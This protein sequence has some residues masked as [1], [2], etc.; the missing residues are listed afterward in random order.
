MDISMIMPVVGIGITVV[1]FVSVMFFVFRLFRGL[2]KAQARNQELLQ[3][4]IP[5]PARVASVQM[6]GMTVTTGV[7]RNLQ[8]VI[9]LQV[10]PQGGQPYQAQMTTMVSELQVPQ[11]QPGSWVQIRY[12]RNNAQRMALEAV[13]IPAPGQQQARFR[14]QGGGK[15]RANATRRPGYQ[16]H[17][18]PA[19]HLSNPS[20]PPCIDRG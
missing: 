5:A 6:G 13:G 8:L 17:A 19:R 2:A 9:A 20:I 3:N 14:R 12:D 7:S 4:G 10:Y 15:R 16:R 18:I 1:V 11:V